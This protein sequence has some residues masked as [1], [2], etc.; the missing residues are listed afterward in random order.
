[1]YCSDVRSELSRKPQ[2][3]L[4]STVKGSR[5]ASNIRACKSVLTWNQKVTQREKGSG[6]THLLKPD[7]QER[8][9]KK[10]VVDDDGVKEKARR[11][12]EERATAN[13][14]SLQ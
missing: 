5:P 14:K 13:D 2:Y 3:N 11:A 1:M 7:A 9:C 10:E 8:S 12:S 4:Y 6:I